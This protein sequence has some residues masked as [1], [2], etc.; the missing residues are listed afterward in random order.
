MRTNAPAASFC[1]PFLKNCHTLTDLLNLHKSIEVI[2]Y[3]SLTLHV[4]E[5][6]C[7]MVTIVLGLYGELLTFLVGLV[8]VNYHNSGNWEPDHNHQTQEDYADSKCP[9]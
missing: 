7:N 2:L 5:A 6:K 4:Y 3:N 8:Y 1:P 9:W